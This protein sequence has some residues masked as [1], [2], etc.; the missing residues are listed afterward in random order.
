M[1]KGKQW[2]KVHA[3]FD[4][5]EMWKKITFFFQPAFTGHSVDNLWKNNDFNLL[6]GIHPNT[7]HTRQKVLGRNWSNHKK[8]AFS[9]RKKHQIT[10]RGTKCV[11]SRWWVGQAGLTLCCYEIKKDA[12][13]RRRSQLA[14]G[15]QLVT[16]EPLK[17]FLRQLPLHHLCRTNVVF[18]LY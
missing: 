12:I 17:L 3:R 18:R 13:A 6:I 2:F 15:T 1:N 10:R 7:L 9:G 5:V 16:G 4:F 14:T 11:V 8:N